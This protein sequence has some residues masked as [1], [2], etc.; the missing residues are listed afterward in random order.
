MEIPYLVGPLKGL[1]DGGW[2]MIEWVGGAERPLE[3]RG[4][5]HFEVI[6]AFL[7]LGVIV[8]DRSIRSAPW[9]SRY[10]TFGPRN[11][12]CNEVCTTV[13]GIGGDTHRGTFESEGGETGA[14]AEGEVVN[15]SNP[16]RKIV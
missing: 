15:T 14:V 8:V 10:F 13:E 12:D 6:G 3:V 4:R 2:W 11:V 7:A 9:S 5:I 1:S 16:F